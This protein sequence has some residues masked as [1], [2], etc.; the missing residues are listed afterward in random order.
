V[1]E[2]KEPTTS[3]E[4]EDVEAHGYLERPVGE[5]PAAEANTEEA[6]VEAHSFVEKP[7]DMR[8]ADM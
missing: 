3:S 2:N 7:V 5:Q 6:D 8:P 4:D 1:E